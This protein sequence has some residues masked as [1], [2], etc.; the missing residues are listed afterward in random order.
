[1]KKM[2]GSFAEKESENVMKR[3]E[4]GKSCTSPKPCKVTQKNQKETTTKGKKSL[5]RFVCAPK[6]NNR[7]L[8]PLGRK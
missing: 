6:S 7:E 5:I 4:L 3:Q 2:C 8:M 1:M